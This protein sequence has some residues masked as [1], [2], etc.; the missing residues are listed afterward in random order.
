MNRTAYHDTQTAIVRREID[1][2]GAYD[3]FIAKVLSI[4]G[5]TGNPVLQ[6]IGDDGTKPDKVIFSYGPTLSPLANDIV[7]VGKDERGRRVIIGKIADANTVL[8]LDAD[9]IYG[10]PAAAP[11]TTTTSHT[12][13]TE[14]NT[15]ST[16]YVDVKEFLLYLYGRFRVALDIAS[17]TA[18][19][20]ATL[21]RLVLET[22]AGDIVASGEV[23]SQSAHSTFTS[24]TLDMNISG[25]PGAILKVQYKDNA[26][27]NT[28]YIKNVSV[29]YTPIT[30]IT[31]LHQ[32]L[33][34]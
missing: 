13:N 8:A 34:D 33:V 12:A 31:P 29:K 21:A 26:G 6:I 19:A 22:A 4:D 10:L 14:R 20:D 15:T 16:S 1:N 28:A 11:G 2:I 17:S 24:R 25:W 27:G 32:V 18:N 9:T 3:L 30:T 23:G 7:L 5:A